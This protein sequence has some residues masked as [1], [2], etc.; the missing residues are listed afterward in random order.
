[1]Q[2]L[3]EN[4]RQIRTFTGRLVTKELAASWFGTARISPVNV[5]QLELGAR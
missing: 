2:K 3:R 5:V 1:M 4:Y